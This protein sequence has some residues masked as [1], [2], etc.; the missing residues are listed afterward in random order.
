MMFWQDEPLVNWV[1]RESPAWSQET[2]KSWEATFPRGGQVDILPFVKRSEGIRKSI[3]MRSV[4][5]QWEHYAGQSWHDALLKPQYKEGKMRRTIHLFDNKPEYYFNSV[6]K[7]IYF[8][9][10]CGQEW[11]TTGGGNHRT[12]VA[13]FA[14]AM[15]SAKTDDSF[16]LHNVHTRLYT[17]DWDA[18][19]LFSQLMALIKQEKIDIHPSVERFEIYSNLSELDPHSLEIYAPIFHISDF[20]LR[21]EGL[22]AHLTSNQ[23]CEYASWIIRNH[24]QVTQWEKRQYWWRF[25]LLK[26]SDRLIYPGLDRAL[27]TNK[28]E[29]IEGLKRI[30][31]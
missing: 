20:R 1:Q 28:R 13:K 8:S 16:E 5:G 29:Y 11:Y 15:A 18:F 24:G 23:F 25:F 26:D 27:F 30:Y 4:V 19:N 10:V 17:V 12:V 9:S 7:D 21:R 22:F 3:N 2:I 6:E 14:L 31:V